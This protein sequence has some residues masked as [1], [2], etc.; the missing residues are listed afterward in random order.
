MAFVVSVLLAIFVLDPPWSYLAVAG[1]ATVE[2][3]ESGAMLWYSRRRAARVGVQTLIGRT[4]T[5]VD[6]CH[7]EGQVKVDGE[8]WR[9]RCP[10]GADPGQEVRVESIEGL[11]LVVAR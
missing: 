11:T 10:A 4:A 5:V 8:L 6:P 9:A 3:T 7:P 2:L 1:G